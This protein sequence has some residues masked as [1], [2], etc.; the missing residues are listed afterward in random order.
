[1]PEITKGPPMGKGNLLKDLADAAYKDPGE[2]YSA[3]MPPEI[4]GKNL[5]VLTYT[6]AAKLAADITVKNGRIW[7]RF[8]K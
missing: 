3:E 8:H 6:A 4:H 7:I 2:W 5:H 1:M